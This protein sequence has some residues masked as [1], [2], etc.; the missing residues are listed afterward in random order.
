MALVIEDGSIVAGAN[1]LVDDTEFTTYASARGL[2]VPSTA[3]ERE[4]LLIKGMDYLNTRKYKGR[5][6][7]PDDQELA[8][9]R[10]GIYANDDYI[11]SDQIPKE[12]KYAQMEAAIAS[13]TQ[14]L[15]VN[16]NY[17]NIQKE[18]LD[19]LEVNY[20]SGGKKTKVRLGRVNAWL[21][22]FL[23]GSSQLVR[24]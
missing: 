7:Y 4:I 14:D 5:R 21:K 23:L 1:S 10:Y 3:A 18:K 17:Q 19:V 20:H 9:P 2:T 22:P 15:V 13:N 11:E 6:T 16:E 8:F 12:V 24:T